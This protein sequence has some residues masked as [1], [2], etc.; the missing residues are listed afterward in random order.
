LF[1]FF[2]RMEPY[3][4]LENLIPIAK[5]LNVLMPNAKIKILGAGFDKSLK[6]L[7]KLH[8]IEI[9]N[10]FVSEKELNNHLKSATAVLLP[11]NNATQS[12]VLLKSFSQGVPVVAFDVGAIGSYLQ[13]GYDGYLVKHKDF[14]NFCDKMLKISKNR[15]FFYANIKNSFEHRYGIKALVEQYEQ[16]LEDL[17]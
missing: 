10:K 17:S 13:D 3:K 11:Y 7:N 12:G 4:G 1:I 9:L 2:G 5:R 8:N 15:S 14:D 16:L 6:E